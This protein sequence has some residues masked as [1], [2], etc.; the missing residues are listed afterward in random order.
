MS[1]QPAKASPRFVPE[2]TLM[3]W[4]YHPDEITPTSRPTERFDH[5]VTTI[6]ASIDLTM[7]FL[8]ATPTPF[9]GWAEPARTAQRGDEGQ[10]LF[11]PVYRLDEE[12]LI[13]TREGPRTRSTTWN[14]G[15]DSGRHLMVETVISYSREDIYRNSYSWPTTSSIP[16]DH[17]QNLL[18]NL[19]WFRQKLTP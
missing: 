7:R 2:K 4:F 11:W 3:R 16:S 1:A 12:R 17:Q 8:T 9:V 10:I 18:D 19:K 5:P 14:Y 6:R 13:D 15:F